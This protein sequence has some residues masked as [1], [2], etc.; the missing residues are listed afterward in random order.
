MDSKA[1]ATDNPHAR[2]YSGRV[3]ALRRDKRA[4]SPYPERQGSAC[5]A[6]SVSQ[7]AGSSR[8]YQLRQ[9]AS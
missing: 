6:V 9:R 8:W 2:M 4:R 1:K 5:A 7:E 3:L